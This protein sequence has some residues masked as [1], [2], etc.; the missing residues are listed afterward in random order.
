M[1]PRSPR[2]WSGSPRSSSTAAR[3]TRALFR[4]EQADLLSPEDPEIRYRKGLCLIALKQPAR[5]IEDLTFATEHA[6]QRADFLVSLADAYD[7][8]R[9]PERARQALERAA[10]LQPG[11]PIARQASER[12]SR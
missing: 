8:D 9:Q 4:L 6:P 7:A 2:R 11:S 5:A 1:T 12:L 3:P 10:R